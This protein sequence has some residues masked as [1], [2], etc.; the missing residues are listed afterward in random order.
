VPAVVQQLTGYRH[1]ADPRLRQL[2]RESEESSRERLH[3]SLALLPVDATQIDYLRKCLKSVAPA[4]LRVLCAALAPHRSRLIPALW[5]ELEQAGP[6]DPSLLNSAAALALYDPDGPRWSDLGGK[7]AEALVKV[8]PIFLG[9]WLDAL[10]PVRAQLAGP[11][12][13]IFVKQGSE[14]EHELATSVL[15]DYVADEPDRVASLLMAAAA[16][17]FLALFPIAERQP[18][19]ALP[20]LRAELEKQAP[21]DWHDPPLDPSLT[22]P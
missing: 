19:R 7:V 2:L 3:A 14:T 9:H 6:A 18:N 4:E 13:R 10:R 22:K 16:K 8:N 17:S 15:A 20:A 12:E 11:L 21:F 5:T 1:W